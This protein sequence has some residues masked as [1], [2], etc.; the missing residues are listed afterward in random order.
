M[1]GEEE[2]R[3]TIYSY[4]KVWKVEKKIYTLGNLKLPVPINPYRLLA[5]VGGALFMVLLEKLL[6]AVRQIPG[7]IRY[8]AFPYLVANYVLKVKLDGKNP[9]MF[10]FG[11]IRFLITAKGRYIQLFRRYPDKRGEKLM[12]D[13]SCSM[14]L[15][16][17]EA[18]EKNV[19]VSDSIFYK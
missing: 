19:S 16:K 6:P 14:R 1:G 7:I 15:P 13:W 12:L 2:N 18:E 5:Y 8:I 4:E 9:V 11:Y 10:L 3:V 17:K